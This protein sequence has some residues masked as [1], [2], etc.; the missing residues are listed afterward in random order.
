M[1][2]ATLERLQRVIADAAQDLL[3]EH[4]AEMARAWDELQAQQRNGADYG[5]AYLEGVRAER[6]RTCGLIQRE[7]AQANRGSLAHQRLQ[8]LLTLVEPGD[9]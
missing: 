4:Q 7:M 2:P 3:L 9:A 5:R 8:R 6:Q 1:K